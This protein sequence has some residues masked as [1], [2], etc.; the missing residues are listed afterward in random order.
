MSGE[1]KRMMMMLEGRMALPSPDYPREWIAET[2]EER[3][4]LTLVCDEMCAR[5]VQYEGS[6]AERVILHLS[7]S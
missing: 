4:F 5:Y 6:P 2:L 7:H 1:E 3:G